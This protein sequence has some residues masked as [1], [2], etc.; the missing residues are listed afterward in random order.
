[1]GPVSIASTADD[2]PL[3]E[4]LAGVASARFAAQYA[5]LVVPWSQ[6]REGN[7]CNRPHPMPWHGVCGTSATSSCPVYGG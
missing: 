2:L 6:S 3:I 1:M 5:A 4:A 7:P